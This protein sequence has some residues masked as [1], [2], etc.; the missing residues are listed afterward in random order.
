MGIQFGLR[1]NMDHDQVE[2]VLVNMQ[3]VE[4]KVNEFKVWLFN[5][6]LWL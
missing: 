2:P 6:D 1:V 5:V 3:Q 4:F